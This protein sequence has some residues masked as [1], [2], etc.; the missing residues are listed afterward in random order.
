MKILIIEDEKDIAE[1]LERSLVNSGFSVDIALDG[2][3]GQN[4]AMRNN[5]DCILLDLN[6][7]KIDGIELTKSIR[8]NQNTV[9]IIMLTARSQ[10]YNKLEG[11]DS[12]ADDYVTKPF[13][14]KELIARIKAIIKRNSINKLETLYL[15]TYELIPDQN[16]VTFRK[17]NKVTNEIVLSNKE[18]ALLEYLIRNKGKIISAEELL[19]HVWDTEIDMFTETVKTHIK[20]LRKKLDPDKKLIKTVRGKGYLIN[21]KV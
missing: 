12:G 6:L 7:P 14:L 21:Y 16:K 1:P 4:L 20:T 18:T 11:F 3:K 10:I 17:S 13:E 9:P 8:D 2:E 15:G 19:E 5:Y